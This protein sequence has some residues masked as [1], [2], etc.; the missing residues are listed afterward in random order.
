M[1]SQP[2]RR[3]TQPIGV[4]TPKNMIPMITGLT[5][6]CISAPSFI[7]ARLSGASHSSRVRVTAA[8]TAAS[9]MVHGWKKAR[10]VKTPANSQPKLRFEGSA[11]SMPLKITSRMD[12]VVD[13]RHSV[14]TTATGCRL[15]RRLRRH[16]AGRPEQSHDLGGSQRGRGAVPVAVHR[17]EIQR[18][19][20]LAVKRLRQT[21]QIEYK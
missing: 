13:G 10:M 11:V 7:Q 2:K 3:I 17:L 16:L 15:G 5:T 19:P 6:A 9:A 20:V 8:N 12:C 14:G 18:A 1:A 21:G 4:K